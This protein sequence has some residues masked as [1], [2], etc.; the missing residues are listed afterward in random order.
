MNTKNAPELI[1]E[2][3]IRHPNLNIGAGTVCNMK[4]LDT[5]TNAGASFIVS[6]IFSEELIKECNQRD[7]AVFP[8]S[9]NPN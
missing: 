3:S 4:D 6:P 2:F 8:R 1:K 9:S 5:A 7:M